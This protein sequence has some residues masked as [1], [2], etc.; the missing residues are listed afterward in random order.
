MIGWE[1]IVVQVG[2]SNGSSKIFGKGLDFGIGI[3]HADTATSE[4][5]GVFRIFNQISSLR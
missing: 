1:T 4:D 2:A 5:N 3:A